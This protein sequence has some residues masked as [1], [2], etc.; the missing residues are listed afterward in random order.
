[1]TSKE[2]DRLLAHLD[3]DREA[4]GVKYK[5]LH[6]GLVNFFIHKGHS[7]PED[8]ADETLDRVATKLTG[9]EQIN[10]IKGFAV[11]VAR[12]I[13]LED[14]RKRSRVQSA[15]DIAEYIRSITESADERLFNLMRRCLDRLPSEDRQFIDQYYIEGS[16]E[17]VIQH[18]LAL[19]D[20][21]NVTLNTLR[22]RIH[23][24]RQKLERCLQA[25][26][27]LLE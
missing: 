16:N 1:L 3:A 8:G 15:A 22:L 26:R 4:A 19:A 25:G 11:A 23:R 13:F 12:I 10:N 2:L 27:R 9:G 24:L 17:C 18:R 6:T 5:E 20:R 7:Q 21:M 14:Q